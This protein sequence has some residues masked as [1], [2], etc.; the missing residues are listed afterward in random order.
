MVALLRNLLGLRT[1][2]TL[3]DEVKDYITVKQS[4]INIEIPKEQIDNINSLL[5][6]EKNYLEENTLNFK[7]FSTNRVKYKLI[8]WYD[9]IEDKR[10]YETFVNGENDCSQNYTG[11]KSFVNKVREENPSSVI[12]VHGMGL[13]LNFYL[14]DKL[15]SEPNLP[16]GY[17]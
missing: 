1:R 9:K 4:L 10:L 6:L 15:L 8:N 17:R 2:K 3:A 16:Y 11:T 14:I 7:D 12:L 5:R 13:E